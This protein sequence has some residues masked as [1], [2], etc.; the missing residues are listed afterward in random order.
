MC[1][2]HA[3][4][5]LAAAISTACERPPVTLRLCVDLVA[6]RFGQRCHADGRT[7]LGAGAP[8]AVARR[9]TP[10]STVPGDGFRLDAA[11][12]GRRRRD[13]APPARQWLPAGRR[14]AGGGR[15]GAGGGRRGRHDRV[16]C[17]AEQPAGRRRPG[18]PRGGR[19]RPRMAGLPEPCGPRGTTCAPWRRCWVR[20]C[21]SSGC[22]TAD[23]WAP[24]CRGRRRRR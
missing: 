3:R 12:A 15:R 10:E 19:R 5:A 1:C 22:A 23:R 7:A 24:C 6:A 9:S 17:A 14:G 20:R 16:Q 18:G 4:S 8:R 2:C 11:G 21:C 13:S